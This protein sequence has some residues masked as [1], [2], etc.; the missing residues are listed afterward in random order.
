MPHIIIKLY[1]GKSEDQKINLVE[2]ITTVVCENLNL[3]ESSISVSIE[4]VPPELWAKE[5]YQKD[6][7]DNQENLYKKPG[8]KPKEN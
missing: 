5:V 8:Y 2:N 4:E 1:P 3:N 7:I 6:I